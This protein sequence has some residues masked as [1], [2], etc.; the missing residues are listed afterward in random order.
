MP[1]A[2]GKKVPVIVSFKALDEL[3]EPL[4]K[5]NQRIENTTKPI[6]N[7]QNQ[8]SR[9][10]RATGLTTFLAGARTAAL[11]MAAAIAAAGFAAYKGFQMIIQSQV[12]A[13]STL[14][15][16]SERTRISV[17]DLQKFRYVAEQTGASTEIMDAALGKFSKVL[18]QTR[19]GT[20]PL[21]EL[22][23]RDSGI[24]ANLN[25]AKGTGK[26]FEYLMKQ[27]RA[28]PNEAARFELI[29]AAFGKG[30]E[31]LVNMTYL[32]D[33]ET[34]KL[35]AER[36]A[37]GLV[38]QEQA[39]AFKRFGDLEKKISTRFSYLTAIVGSKLLPTFEKLFTQF[40]TWLSNHKQEIEEF[41]DGLAKL[42]PAGL[43]IAISLAGQL[44]VVFAMI[45]K[46]VQLI[47]KYWD[48]VSTKINSVAD[49]ITVSTAAGF[50]LNPAKGIADIFS[51]KSN[52]GQGPATSGPSLSPAAVGPALPGYLVGPQAGISGGLTIKFENAPK[53]MRVDAP[54]SFG[55]LMLDTSVG[56]AM[57]HN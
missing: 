1:A 16:L 46:A 23:G 32:T 25:R 35:Y 39:E 27:L 37:I 42:L 2:K 56:Y 52:F 24:V 40:D 29:G 57:E 36:E 21:V 49:K 3:S 41:G 7:F 18:S 12:E 55:A 47:G 14:A 19:R 30:N 38:S 50:I 9:F 8:V 11:G 6:K 45:I 31:E 13:N 28:V 22:L 17:G 33:E 10:G 34:K 20:G 53:G 54:S 4:R 43:A 5:L 44:L 48:K 15:D 26:A 51:G